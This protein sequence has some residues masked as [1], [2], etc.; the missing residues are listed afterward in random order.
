MSAINIR[1]P[2]LAS[3]EF[4]E[5]PREIFWTDMVPGS[6]RPAGEGTDSYYGVHNVIVNQKD[7]SDI[8]QIT[9]RTETLTVSLS[10]QKGIIVIIL[11][12]RIAFFS[13]LFLI[14]FQLGRLFS[15]IY[16]EDPFNPECLKR[17]RITGFLIISISPLLLLFNELILLAF[18]NYKLSF[19][20]TIVSHNL[21]LWLIITGLIVF[22]FGYAFKIGSELR[23][24]T[25][26]T[27]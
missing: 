3:L 2:A 26:L 27:I 15:A 5:F 11:L 19:T 24:D 20:S 23:N 14:S 17:L 25:E 7:S 4:I 1:L 10:D 22:V 13:V 21:N 18:R 16:T 12:K 9:T 8:L 6:D